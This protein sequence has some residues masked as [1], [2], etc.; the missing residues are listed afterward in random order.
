MNTDKQLK[1]NFFVGSDTQNIVLRAALT[2]FSSYGFKRTSMEDIAQ[3]AGVSRPTLYAYFKHKE[4]ILQRVSE[5]IHES[6]LNDIDTHLKSEQPLEQ[7]LEK[8]FWAWTQPFMEIL[9]GSPHGAELIGASSAMASDVS[10][11]A[12]EGFLLVLA[13]T[14]D[15]AQ[16]GGKLD[17][18]TM[19]LDAEKAAEFL[20]LSLNGL[21]TGEANERA[22]KKRLRTLVSVFLA[23]TSYQEVL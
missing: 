15:E 4:A 13:S 12:F 2:R 18:G 10:A 17:L 11:R 23:A 5:G 6:V 16:K 3:E 20:V 21:S 7:R 8:C 22:Y 19:N 1:Q 9:F 14:L